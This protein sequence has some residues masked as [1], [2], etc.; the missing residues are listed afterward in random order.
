MVNIIN[1]ANII[2]EADQVI[3]GTDNIF[4]GQCPDCG[5]DINFQLFINLVSSYLAKVIALRI[6]E[7]GNK[8]RSAAV[9]GRRVTRP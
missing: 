7:A 2:T 5:R 6:G 1:G 3:D 8:D 4:V 9:N